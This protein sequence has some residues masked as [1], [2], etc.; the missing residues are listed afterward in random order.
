MIF[1]KS[2]EWWLIH[3]YR[4]LIV[5]APDVFMNEAYYDGKHPLSFVTSKYRDQFG[6]MLQGVSDNWMALVIDAVEERMHVQGFR[7]T[8][9]PEGDK[10][11]WKIWQ[12]NSL[13]VDSEMLHSVALQ[14]GSAYV[15]VGYGDNERPLITVEHPAQVYVAYDGGNRH[16]RVAAIKAWVD[17]WTGETR[18]NIY[19]PD[20]IYKFIS[21]R[22]VTM[23]EYTTASG[24]ERALTVLG[25][26]WRP[27][28]ED[29]VDNPLGAVPI[30]EFRNRPRMLGEGRSEIC[31]VISV[32]NQINKLVCDM[33]I[34]SEFAAFKQRWATGVEIP[35]DPTTGRELDDFKS[36]VDRLWHVEDPAARFGEFS[37]TDLK[38]YTTAIENRVQ[39]LASRTRTP[40]HYLLGASGSFPSGESLKATEAGLIN[41]VRSR[42]RHFGESWELVMRLAFGVLD[43]PRAD[44]V[45]AETIWVDPESRNEAVLADS[46]LKRMALG[47]PHEQL[48]QDAGYTQSQIARF[49]EMLITE[50]LERPLQEVTSVGGITDTTEK[51]YDPM[52]GA[53]V[54]LEARQPDLA[55]TAAA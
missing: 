42:H 13:D 18:A 28:T 11:A 24:R 21:Q 48:W 17:E 55:P 49:K 36:A 15:M 44:A 19:L 54:A 32:Q 34:A 1:E 38:N 5:R 45:T 9:Q 29:T 10:D 6:K 30:V 33:M 3:L 16:E 50:A 22:Q 35:T 7:M 4:R 20:G 37:G 23:D 26:M 14:T 47:V 41:K 25:A 40:P 31:D 51:R 46:L 8:D 52:S 43:D 39:S 27:L 2:P 53:A 12:E